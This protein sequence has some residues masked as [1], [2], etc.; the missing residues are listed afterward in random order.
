MGP[1][2]LPEHVQSIRDR[3]AAAAA[4]A[5]RSVE[6]ITLLA[7]S[8]DQ[9]AESVRAAAAAGVRDF[10][11]SYLQEGL[12]KM[13]SLGDLPLVWHFI[14]RLQANKTRPVAA[15]FDWV[16]GIDRLRIAERLSQQRSAH[17]PPLNLCL[18]VNLAGEPT[19]GGVSMS[20]LPALAQAVAK[21]PRVRLRGLMCLPPDETEPT[22]QRYWF[23]ALRRQLESLNAAGGC[24]DTLSMGMS[25]DFE[26]AVLEGA[27]IVRIG[28][29]LFGPRPQAK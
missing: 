25:G 24:L 28:T 2:N 19:K 4:A 26:A 7:A 10:G 1:Q 29:A 23:A 22:R 20:E 5:G 27:T 11:E 13:A 21:L 15:A 3:I 9:S 6:S 12:D 17:S 18:Q 8:K 14:G 16:H